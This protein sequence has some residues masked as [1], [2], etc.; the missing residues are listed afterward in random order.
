MFVSPLATCRFLNKSRSQA[1][2]VSSAREPEPEPLSSTSQEPMSPRTRYA[3]MKERRQRLARSRSSHN[4]GAEEPD[5]DEDPPSPTTQSPT[6]YLAAKYGPGSELARSRSTHALKSR[7]PSPDRD[8]PG[9]EKDG[10]ALSSWAR[11]LKNKYGNRTAKD[12]EP[13]SASSAL[14]SSR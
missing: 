7:E 10:A 14:P 9:A 5:I 11:Y 12:K 6:A 8:R 1:A 2:M 3:A 13:P 4:F